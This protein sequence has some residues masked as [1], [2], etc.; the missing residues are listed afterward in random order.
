MARYPQRGARGRRVT[1]GERAGAIEL[2]RGRG[3]EDSRWPE[4]LLGIGKRRHVLDNDSGGFAGRAA[5][6]WFGIAFSLVAL[7]IQGTMA[8]IECAQ[9]VDHREAP[10]DET[11]WITGSVVQ[12]RPMA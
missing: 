8:L 12:D 3:I 9:I 4:S 5:R 7:E 10:N 11:I 1:T 2:A 6:H